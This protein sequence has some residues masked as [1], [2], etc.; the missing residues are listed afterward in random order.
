[1][2]ELGK[3]IYC[4]CFVP[5]YNRHKILGSITSEGVIEILRGHKNKTIISTLKFL[6]SC[7]DC[8]YSKYINLESIKYAE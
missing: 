3:A 6:M 2:N 5:E 4:E 7:P 8:G 1:M